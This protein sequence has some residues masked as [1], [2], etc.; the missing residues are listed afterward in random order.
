MLRV[1][2]LSARGLH[3]VRR[4]ARTLADLAGAGDLVDEEHIATALAMR[5]E[6]VL[7]AAAIL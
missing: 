2:A 4:V 7:E 6:S 1:G 5:A 3:R